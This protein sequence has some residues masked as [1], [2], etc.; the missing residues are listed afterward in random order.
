MGGWDKGSVTRK[1]CGC[2]AEGASKAEDSSVSGFHTDVTPRTADLSRA[3][4]ALTAAV[5]VSR[6]VSGGRHQ[7]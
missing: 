5:R 4:Q 3:H 7:L 2:R 6:P 1:A